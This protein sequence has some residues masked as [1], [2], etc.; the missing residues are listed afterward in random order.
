MTLPSVPFPTEPVPICVT[1]HRPQKLGGYSPFATSALRA[2]AAYCLQS[3][4]FTPPL[5]LTGMALGWD[6][7]IAH[8]CRSLSIP[9]HAYIPFPSQPLLWSPSDQSLYRDLLST[10]DS[11]ITCFPDPYE[12]WKMQHRNIRMIVA[13]RAVLACWDGS[14]GGTANCI[15]AARAHSRPILNCYDTF[16]AQSL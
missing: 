10:A 6:L 15:R 7:A 5:V 13:S 9:Y 14:S 12:P 11:V 1:G 4:P 8:A 16:V 2:V 3:L